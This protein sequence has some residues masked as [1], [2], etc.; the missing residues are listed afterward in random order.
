LGAF[1][2]QFN[3][4]TDYAFRVVLFLAQLPA[5]T[6]IGG[7]EI[8]ASQNIPSR[9]L[10]K[11]MRS[12]LQAGIIKS[13]RGVEGGYALVKSPAAISLY[14][15]IEAMEGPVVIQRCLKDPDSCTR[16]L[17]SVCEVHQALGTIQVTLVDKLRSIN[18][19]VLAQGKQ[20]S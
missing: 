2:I 12:L 5:D 4:A 9:F 3:Q 8:A 1:I 18:F 7:P 15:V 14:D 6:I 20:E 16:R 13:F 19:A 11:I 17:A 10:L